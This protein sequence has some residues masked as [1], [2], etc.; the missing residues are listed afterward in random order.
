MA[1]VEREAPSR[2]KQSVKAAVSSTGTT[3]PVKPSGSEYNPAAGNAFTAYLRWFNM[4]PAKPAQALEQAHVISSK[5]HVQ[6]E[7]KAVLTTYHIKVTPTVAAPKKDAATEPATDMAETKADAAPT[8][9]DAAPAQPV[10]LELAPRSQKI[11]AASI[12]TVGTTLFIASG[13]VAA[14][15]ASSTVAALASTLVLIVSAAASGVGLIAGAATLALL[16]RQFRKERKATQAL[17]KIETP[18]VDLNAAPAS[19]STEDL[20]GRHH[21]AAPLQVGARSNREKL[22]L[23]AN[24]LLA[25]EPLKTLMNIEGSKTVTEETIKDIHQDVSALLDKS[26]TSDDEQLTTARP[27][28]A[29]LKEVLERIQPGLPPVV[30]SPSR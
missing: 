26:N 21:A 20:A 7:K 24:R 4:N 12:S 15:G 18:E 8:A 22:A 29:E 27:N 16:A 28:L 10:S 23:Q 6:D 11:T 13:T 1:R 25:A 17:L 2:S 19:T 3:A 9:V 5:E 14:L 30:E